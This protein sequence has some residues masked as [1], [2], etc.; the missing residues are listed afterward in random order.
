VV[1]GLVTFGQACALGVGY[2]LLLALSRRRLRDLATVIGSVIG[3]GS[4]ALIRLFGPHADL[5]EWA[6]SEVA[7]NALGWSPTSWFSDLLAWE[8]P[9]RF[10]DLRSLAAPALAL[11]SSLALGGWV[12]SRFYERAGESGQGDRTTRAP[13]PRGRVLPPAIG[14]VARQTLAVIGREPQLRAL[15]LQQLIFLLIPLLSLRDDRAAGFALFTVPF[16]IVFSH[17][18]MSMSLLGIDGP[19]LRLLIQSPASRARI[20]LGR[21]FAVLQVF[22]LIDL[23]GCAALVA[24]MSAMGGVEDPVRR[25]AEI[26]TACLV[27]D[28]VM[29]GAGAFVSVLAPSPI[30]RRSRSMR[31]RQEGCM[32]SI[33]KTVIR[34]PVI[35]CAVLIGLGTVLPAVVRLDAAWYLATVPSGLLIAAAIVGLGVGFG[36]RRLA[37]REERV[38]AALA[39][40]GE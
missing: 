9:E 37:E 14:A 3:I 11:A 12:F 15:L 8:D 6:A 20:L 23:L 34:L 36:A 7:W 4:Y 40:A 16:F 17:A 1:F 31:M 2:L 22:A 39:E 29:V 24:A 27:A 25:F 18:W 32:T 28:T 33:G 30:V 35:A 19:G 5:R 38:V 13:P 21:A 10:R 26:A